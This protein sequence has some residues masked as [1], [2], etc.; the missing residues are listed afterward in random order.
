MILH[1]LKIHNFRQFAGDQEIV[2]SKDPYK[3]ATIIVGESGVGKTTLVQIF[4]WIFYGQCKYSKHSG[5]INGQLKKSMPAGTQTNVHCEISF[6]FNNLDYTVKRSQDF[7]KI[8]TS[9]QSGKSTLVMKYIDKN[10]IS[11]KKVNEEAEKIIK[12]IINSDLFPYFFL[13]GESLVKVGNEMSSGSSGK[14]SNFSKAV[15]GLLG[16][17][18]LYSSRDHLKSL[19]KIY[20]KEI[21]KNTTDEQQKKIIEIIQ[22][23]EEKIERNNQRLQNI[24]DNI[25]HFSSLAKRSSDQIMQFSDAE[26]KE[27][28]VIQLAKE[29]GNINKT[30]LQERASIFNQFSQNSYKYFMNQ[31][32]SQSKEVFADEDKIEKGIPGINSTAIDFLLE[33]HECICG[34]KLIEGSDEWNKLVK[35]KEYLPP[36]SIGAEI[37]N[38]KKLSRDMELSGKKYLEDFK[39]LRT[40]ISR[41]SEMSKN[42]Q[43]EYEKLN[44]DIKNI[45]DVSDLKKQAIQYEHKRD[46][47]FEEKGALKNENNLLEDRINSKNKE[48]QKFKN[49]NEKVKKLNLYKTYTDSILNRIINYCDKKEKEKKKELEYEIN[50]I[51]KDFYNESISFELDENYNVQIKT[52]INEFTD[53]FS[54]GGQVVVIALAFIGAIIKI[55]GKKKS[56][57]KTD[58]LCEDINSEVYPLVM[59]APTSNFGMKQM[60]SFCEVMPKVTNQI[61]VFI[62]DKDGPILSKIMNNI[63][64]KRWRIT[65]EDTYHAK[66]MEETL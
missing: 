12:E 61:I 14:N 35:L 9:I 29:I 38:F 18:D 36:I 10:G 8:N 46:S 24:S 53:D 20:M 56:D 57:D 52:N 33:K 13:E 6:E 25:E 59:D 54:S 27:K 23:S 47:L 43:R 60:D 26:E 22:T 41:L 5:V 63:I 32:L 51:F 66:V 40:D 11:K 1:Y 21:E 62:N 37:N 31:L 58:L 45:P 49:I 48:L 4:K 7:T 3:K 16:F 55:N 30:I 19:T 50:N 34:N 28:K 64:G 65:K 2:F 39:K 15:R 44:E 17:N 42:K